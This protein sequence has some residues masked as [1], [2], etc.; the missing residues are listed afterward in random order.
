VDKTHPSVMYITMFHTST[1]HGLNITIN[2]QYL[3]CRYAQNVCSKPKSK[4]KKIKKYSL[5]EK[6]VEVPLSLVHMMIDE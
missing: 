5:A 3:D 1:Y 4:S 6:N 2:K